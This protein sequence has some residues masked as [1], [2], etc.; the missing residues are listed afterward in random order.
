MMMKYFVV[1]QILLIG[2]ELAKCAATLSHQA[3]MHDG[4]TL[5]M[6]IETEVARVAQHV[7]YAE[8]ATSAAD[9]MLVGAAMAHP[10]ILLGICAGAGTSA[11]ALTEL[12]KRARSKVPTLGYG[13]ACAIG[14]VLF[15]VCG[16]LLVLFGRH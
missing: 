3:F 6:V 10:G 15:A 1:G 11:P 12:E 8:Y 2:Q 7:G 4:L 13:L 16:T 14:N 5:T 9:L